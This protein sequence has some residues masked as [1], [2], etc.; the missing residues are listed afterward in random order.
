M[1]AAVQGSTSTGPLRNIFRANLTHQVFQ[2]L[3]TL[4]SL[5][6]VPLYVRYL[7]VERY[8]LFLTAQ[9]CAGYL[10]FGTSS[11]SQS[12][13]ILVS[14][15][16]GRNDAAEL[17]GIVRN[18]LAISAA[19][20]LF[21]IVVTCGIAFGLQGTKLGD[22]VM[23]DHPEVPGLV[24]A[25]GLQ[26]V[27]VIAFSSFYDLLVGLQRAD[28]VALLQGA[29]RTVTQLASLGLVLQ[30][31]S[32]GA[33]TAGG[34]LGTVLAG[35]LCVI[36]TR[37][38][39]P[40][41]FQPAEITRAQITQQVRTAAKSSGLLLGATLAGTAPTVALAAVAGPSS[42]PLYAV[43]ARF[44]TLGTSFVNT[45]S[46]LMQPAFGDA[47]A[48]RDLQWIRSM[49]LL[50]W[51][52][53]LLSMAIASAALIAIGGLFIDVWTAGKLEVSSTMLVSV[54][55]GGV[56]TAL[57]PL[58]YMLSGINRHRAAAVTE[59]TNGA[60]AMVFSLAAV[61][62]LSADWVGVGTL[63]AAACTSFWVLPMQARLQLGGASVAPPLGKW[64]RMGAC[65][66]VVYG[67]ARLMTTAGLAIAPG[68]PWFALI[69]SAASA[70][71]TSLICAAVLDLFDWRA[72]YSRFR[73]QRT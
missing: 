49:L 33:I 16:A 24:M 67:V 56:A 63:L 3:T 20:A 40:Q 26:V 9:A 65:A 69:L 19:S 51:E 25:I 62:L 37:R 4:V 38:D 15:A 46:T 31:A 1:Q 48:R 68:H 43:A 60:L 58:K 32:I 66:V 57:A 53:T 42:V 10:G 34:A 44:F 18:S 45:F 50:L 23:L 64:L 61:K 8:G 73:A 13:M 11:V 14:H 21:V 71:V 59:I 17:S 52:K 39:H 2:L 12:T 54:A 36:R 22:A 30:G 27:S 6:A 5:V 29:S 72:L 47:F 28:L 7:G 55:M 70:G 35:T 41:A